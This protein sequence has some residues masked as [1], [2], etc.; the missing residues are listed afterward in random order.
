MLKVIEQKV[1]TILRPTGIN[2]APYVINPYQGCQ[3]GCLFCY[4]QFSKQAQKEQIPWGEYVKVKIN[5]VEVL[6]N[7]LDRIMPEQVLLGSTTEIF[8]LAEKKY[9]ITENILKILNRRKIKYV[10]M[11]RALLIEEYIDILK[12][13]YCKSIYYTVD[14]VPEEIS[15]ALQPYSS[16]ADEPI[17]MVNK[18][19]DNNLDVV[20]Y[21]CPVMPFFVNNFDKVKK[22][23]KAEKAEFEVINFKMAGIERLLELMEKNF[24]DIALRYR[25]MC[26][27]K[28]LYEDTIA[29]IKEDI[30]KAA[31]NFKKIKIHTHEYEEYFKNKYA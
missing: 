1:T 31:G 9:K 30:Y 15:K 2:L 12:Q 6:E 16:P 19:G 13:G 23:N 4:A 27:D 28:R 14:L 18:L 26:S 24:P 17:A 20:P 22:I 21:F 7:E 25:K 5:A 29:R 8:Q 3:M 10:I 11:T